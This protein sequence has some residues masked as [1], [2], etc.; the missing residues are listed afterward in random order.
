MT[1]FLTTALPTAVLVGSAVLALGCAFL[2]LYTEG[3]D[4]AG[5]GGESPSVAER[6]RGLLPLL[7]VLLA[8][9]DRVAGVLGLPGFVWSAMLVLAAFLSV[10]RWVPGAAPAPTAEAPP[11]TESSLASETVPVRGSRLLALHRAAALLLLALAL[12]GGAPGGVV[13]TGH[14][15]AETGTGASVSSPTAE[16]TAPW[17]AAIGAGLVRDGGTASEPIVLLGAVLA[18]FAGASAVVLVR[19]VR[20][21]GVLLP[22]CESAALALTAISAVLV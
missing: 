9:V 5:D 17:P 8:V 22:A 18:V 2:G 1:A 14:H 15:G 10:P 4:A 21:R 16:E 19:H 3:G 11:G 6:L 7:L 13:Q 12:L 20:R